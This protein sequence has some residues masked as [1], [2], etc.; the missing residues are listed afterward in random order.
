M[1]AHQIVQK[2]EKFEEIMMI[3]EQDVVDFKMPKKIMDLIHGRKYFGCT[4]EKFY[5]RAILALVSCEL[6]SLDFEE[7]KRL[8]TKYQVKLND[9]L[10]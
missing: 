5:E 8:E 9:L 10:I 7:E 3:E 1:E 2:K 4:P 6:S